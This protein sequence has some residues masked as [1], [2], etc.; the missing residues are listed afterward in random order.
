MV[1]EKD[2]LVTLEKIREIAQGAAPKISDISAK[3]QIERIAGLADSAI[4]R[5]QAMPESTEPT[6]GKKL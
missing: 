4:S 2:L 5:N 3:N 1:D 6:E